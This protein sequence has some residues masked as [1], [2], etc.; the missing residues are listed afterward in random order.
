MDRASEQ[1]SERV[2]ELAIVSDNLFITLRVFTG[3]K[4]TSDF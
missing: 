4:Q 3:L 2:S 1:V